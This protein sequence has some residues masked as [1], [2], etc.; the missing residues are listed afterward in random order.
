MQNLLE[1][2]KQR[3]VWAAFVGVLSFA[4]TVLNVQFQVDVPVLTDLLTS[5]GGAFSLLA[6]SVLALWSYLSPKVKNV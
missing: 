6:S 2:A 3:R 4:L 5:F 1:L